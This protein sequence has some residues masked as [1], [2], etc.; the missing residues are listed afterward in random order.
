MLSNI[1]RFL[2]PS[3][4]PSV[5]GGAVSLQ[6]KLFDA[7]RNGQFFGSYTHF[8]GGAFNASPALRQPRSFDT[9]REAY[10]YLVSCWEATSDRFKNAIVHCLAQAA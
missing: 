3:H 10:E 5:I 1:S 7:E 9:E 2:H 4:V 6:V 8:R